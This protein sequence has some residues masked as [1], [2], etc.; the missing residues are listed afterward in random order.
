[1]A[2]LDL[3]ELEKLT[4]PAELKPHVSDERAEARRIVAKRLAQI[5][6]SDSEPLLATL[7]DDRDLLVAVHALT[8]LAAPADA[9]AQATVARAVG[10]RSVTEQDELVAVMRD[11]IGGTGVL[12]LT[13]GLPRDP[14]Q[15]W[16]RQKKIFD[17]LQQLHDPRA[18]DGLVRFIASAP[19]PHYA[20]RAAAELAELGDPRAVPHL[21][22]RLRQDPF[23]IYSGNTDWEEALKRDDNER[24]SAARAIA[25]LAALHSDRPDSLWGEAE[26][27]LLFWA[28]ELPSPHANAMRALAALGSKHALPE[29]RQWAFPNAALPKE[30]QQPPMPEEWIIAQI[31]QRYVGQM[32]DKDSFTELLVNL[33]ARPAQFDASMSALL[34][35]NNAI[36]G[37]SLRALG[38]GA[39]QGLSEWGDSKTVPALLAYMRDPANNEQSRFEAC[40]ALAWVGQAPDTERFID[41]VYRA[42]KDTTADH[43]RRVCL[44]EGLARR[45]THVKGPRLLALLERQVPD[46]ERSAAARSI[47]R[48]GIDA[49]FEQALL[50][51]AHSEVAGNDAVLALVLAGSPD[52]VAQSLE[53]HVK[54][55]IAARLQIVTGIGLALESLSQEDFDGGFLFTVLR[56]ADAAAAAGHA[57]VRDAV[58]KAL[59]N[60]VYDSGPHTLTRTVLRY[61]LYHMAQSKRAL[62]RQRAL[63]A[64]W[65][66]RERGMLLAIAN[67]ASPE[68][69]F[70]QGQAELLL[71]PTP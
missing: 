59:E 45:A 47:A 17:A 71:R 43:F 13:L 22:R 1:M 60:V 62:E 10:R 31:A 67:S 40:I 2:P 6:G 54:S 50:E 33:K 20:Y 30:G 49:Q 4:T 57:W 56:N 27:G 23:K 5:G 24:V 34:A 11:Q 28:R 26:R 37:M 25:D 53:G 42:R 63:R 41:E 51:R 64:L 8:A 12:A 16:Y 55:L 14:K 15:R 39:A 68:A 66:F 61:R 38:I 52:A 65:Y 70:A 69:A 21:V 32:R 9:R 7:A 19:H 3:D 44:L 29:L 58:V 35:G 18:A 46:N 48:A 36:L